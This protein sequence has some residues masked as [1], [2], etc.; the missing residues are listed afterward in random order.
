MVFVLTPFSF[1]FQEI[2]VF[3]QRSNF[4]DGSKEFS[5]GPSSPPP[6]ESVFVNLISS[7]PFLLFFLQ[8]FFSLPLKRGILLPTEA[9]NALGP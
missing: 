3:V 5:F 4:P 8:K 2:P 1:Y 9:R 7:S 6:M